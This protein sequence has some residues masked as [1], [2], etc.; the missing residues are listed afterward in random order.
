MVAVPTKCIASASVGATIGRPIDT[1]C[2]YGGRAMLAPTNM[3]PKCVVGGVEDADPY[4]GRLLHVYGVDGGAVQ[5]GGDGTGG[6]LQDPLAAF[7]GRPSHMGR[8]DTVGRG[9]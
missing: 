2:R 6:D 3:Y 9:K 7:R 4:G 8:D 5:E 1:V